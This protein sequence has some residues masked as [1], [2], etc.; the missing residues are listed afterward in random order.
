MRVASIRTCTVIGAPP[1]VIRCVMR[2]PSADC[3]IVWA[4]RHENRTA[5]ARTLV[6]TL[7]LNR[8]SWATTNYRLPTTNYR[9]PTTNYQLPTTN[10]QLPRHH[11][12]ARQE[13]VRAARTAHN[14]PRKSNRKHA[15]GDECAGDRIR[16]RRHEPL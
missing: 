3:P 1:D 6:I 9:L 15:H 7:L 4:V 2:I 12:R 14:R 11:P 10:Y 13:I 5:T 16:R 8:S